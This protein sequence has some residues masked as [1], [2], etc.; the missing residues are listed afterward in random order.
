M[1]HNSK[2]KITIEVEDHFGNPLIVDFLQYTKLEITYSIKD[3]V[4]ASAIEAVS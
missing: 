3:I 4:I 1:E 2:A